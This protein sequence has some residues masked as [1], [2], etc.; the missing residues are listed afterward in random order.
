MKYK[1]KIIKKKD[2][3]STWDAE[4]KNPEFFSMSEKAGSE[5]VKFARYMRKEYGEDYFKYVKALDVGCGNG[6]NLIYIATHGARGL[7]FDIAPSAIEQAKKLS[8]GMALQFISQPMAEKLPAE[9][10][11]IDVVLD[12]MASHCLRE[13]ERVN[14]LSELK[15]VMAPDGYLFLKTFIWEGDQHAKR[16][17][18]QY[19]GG[20]SHSY[21]HPSL[22]VFE[23]VWTEPE[24]RAY[25]APLG[26]I[27]YFDKSH[28][29]QRWG[30][31]PYKRRYVVVY[32]KRNS[33]NDK[34]SE[35]D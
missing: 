12:V 23:H 1:K 34:I 17:C 15:R 16:M 8:Q 18:E 14:Y 30:G 29:Y 20:E 2:V 22:G 4:Y 6:R 5:V 13:S 11:S 31:Q 7:G 35:I 9:D 33:E 25:L 28:G 3:Q 10:E 24:L 26:D 21:I 32:L 19:P 27:E